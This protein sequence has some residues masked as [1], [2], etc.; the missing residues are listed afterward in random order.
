MK[1]LYKARATSKFARGITV[2][3]MSCALYRVQRERDRDRDLNAKRKLLAL[4]DET[5]DFDARSRVAV[6]LPVGK[7]YGWADLRIKKARALPMM[8]WAR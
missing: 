1:A 3:E 5:F 8:E 7:A 6:K 2:N 4:A